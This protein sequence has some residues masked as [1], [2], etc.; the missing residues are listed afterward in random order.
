MLKHL[1]AWELK[2]IKTNSEVVQ[3]GGRSVHFASLMDFCH[4]RHSDL[5]NALQKYKRRQWI[6]SSIHGARSISFANNSSNLSGYNFQIPGRAGEAN[7]AVSAFSQRKSLHKCGYENHSVGDRNNGTR[8]KY[9]WFFLSETCT[10]TRW[11]YWC[12]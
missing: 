11:Q 3:M 12:G 7:D 8:L 4:L 5:A 10:V 2:K 6:Q 1:L 9:Q